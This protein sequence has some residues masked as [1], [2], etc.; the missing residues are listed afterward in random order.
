ME[1]YAQVERETLR[2]TEVSGIVGGRRPPEEYSL[3]PEV[4]QKLRL[5]LPVGRT[6]DTSMKW[7]WDVRRGP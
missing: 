7:T 1:K 4:S 2:L 6:H 5:G 3:L